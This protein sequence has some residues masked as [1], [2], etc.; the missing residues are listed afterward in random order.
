MKASNAPG[1]WCAAA[2]LLGGTLMLLPCVAR[3]EDPTAP[4]PAPQTAAPEVPP[5]PPA[6]PSPPP[7]DPATPPAVSEPAE[8][9]PPAKADPT[10]DADAE[11]R[12]VRR[13][14]PWVKSPIIQVIQV[15]AGTGARAA[16]VPL[17]LVP[18]VGLLALAAQPVVEGLAIVWAGDRLGDGRSAALWPLLVSVL[19]AG[20]A[21]VALVG[22]VTLSVVALVL[23][24]VGQAALGAVASPLATGILL[25]GLTVSLV[26]LGLS[27]VASLLAMVSPVASTLAYQVMKRRKPA[28]DNGADAP[29]LFSPGGP[30]PPQ[31]APEKRKG[32]P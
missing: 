26:A 19:L 7:Q 1:R 4:A 5:A 23:A 16:L 30:E 24:L 17:L 27:T 13:P 9:K 11:P 31:R 2:V 18:G 22:S 12:P 8:A 21:N 14:T 32:K 29:G 3:A 10:Q 25:V 28:E 6:E 15:V 20:T